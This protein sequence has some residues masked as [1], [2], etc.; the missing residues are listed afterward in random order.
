MNPR[1]SSNKNSVRSILSDVPEWGQSTVQPSS[2]G[3]DTLDVTYIQP[4]DFSQVVSVETSHVLAS[5]TYGS[6]TSEMKVGKSLNI[7]VN[8]PLQSEPPIV[9]IWESSAPVLC[10]QF[11]AIRLAV[12]NGFVFGCLEIQEPSRSVLEDVTRQAYEQIFEYCTRS[13]FPNLLRMWNYFPNIN[14]EQDG[15][16]RYK[17]FCIGRHQAFSTQFKEFRPFLPAASAVGTSGGPFQV[18]FLAGVQP[19]IPVENPRQMSAY[20]YPQIYGPKSPSFARATLHHTSSDSRLFVAG[21]AS[22][23]GHATQHHGEPAKQTLETLCNIETILK[24]VR[25]EYPELENGELTQRLLKVFVRNQEDVTSVRQM[26]EGQELGQG[27]ILYVQAHMC[28]KELL[29]E[30]EGIWSVAS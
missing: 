26:L 4:K 17:R 30:I 5:I 11:Q 16:E 27:P 18:L 15:L 6:G 3:S 1:F 13:G 22:I 14:G 9:E 29:V 24:R 28:R 23:V 8:L 21:T 12:T 25:D 20:A 10:D 19:G 2:K 7:Q